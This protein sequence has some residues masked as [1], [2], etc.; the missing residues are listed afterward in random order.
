MAAPRLKLRLAPAAEHSVRAGHPWVFADRLKEI[1][2]TGLAGE[3]AVAYDRHDRFLAIGLYDPGSPIALRVLHH[4]DPVQ[5]DDAWWHDRLAKPL[6]ERS[7]LFDGSTTGYRC[8]NGESDGWPG[9]VLDR[10]AGCYV[11]KL[12]TAAWFPHLERVTDLIE[13]YCRPESLVLRL[14][15]NIQASASSQNRLDGQVL[16]GR[17]VE[18]PVVFC[19][20]GLRFEADVIKGQKTGFFLD[21]RENRRLVGELARGRDVFNVFSHAGGFSV[22]AAAGGASSATDLDISAHALAA[23]KRNFDLNATHPAVRS[24]RHET[25]QGDA[26]KWLAAGQAP[27]HDLVIIDP[28]SLA[29]RES[30]RAGALAAYE[31]LARSGAKLLRPGGIL[32]AASCSAHVKAGEFFQT[33]RESMRRASLHFEELRTTGHAP[34]H[35]ARIPEAEYL[36]CIFLRATRRHR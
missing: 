11:L 15:R 24:C 9:L 30:E 12:Y 19:E 3:L 8:I 36:K 16:R 10:Y 28:P 13:Q 33:V 32:V 5:L 6:C 35:P 23:A 26:F 7:R 17:P 2:R 1:N 18:A 34:D 25:I 20:H 21:Q 29:K 4:G 27:T 14:S 31:Q 22:H